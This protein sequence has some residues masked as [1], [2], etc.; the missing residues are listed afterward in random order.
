[1]KIFITGA[2]GFIGS[3]LLNYLIKNNHQVYALRR[4][5]LNKKFE[6]NQKVS[7]I[8]KSLEELT[9]TD[10]KGIDVVIHLASV[11]VSPKKATEKELFNTN[12][13]G[14]LN[15][16]KIAT[17]SGIRRFVTSGSALEYGREAEKWQKIPPFAQLEPITPYARSKAEGFRL[18]NEFARKNMIEVFYGRIFSAYGTGQ[19]KQ[20][21]WP[22]LY[23]AAISGK[24]FSMT[25]GEQ[26]R[27]FITVEKVAYHL[28]RAA[29][30]LDL[31]P[32][33]PLVVNI[34]SSLG[35][36]LKDFAINEWK[37]IGAE[38]KLNIGKIPSR[39]N[40]IS[41]QV[42]DIRDLDEFK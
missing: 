39:K 30:R 23:Y 4:S 6:C 31:A 7:W 29:I 5:H 20:N 34:G 14:S 17:S 11:G 19:F 13:K 24:D 21:F 9:K 28:Y 42:A 40:E 26:I 33:K 36:S 2:S 16:L 12:I 32:S 10:L 15:L 38:G 8:T 18:I 25:S 27:D 41:R 35:I 1:M 22:S 37:R 3:N